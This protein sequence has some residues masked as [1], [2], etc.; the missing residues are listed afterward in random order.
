MDLIQAFP[1]LKLLPLM[2][3]ACV[4]LTHNTGLY[5]F[6]EAKRRPHSISTSAKGSQS[7]SKDSMNGERDSYVI[8]GPLT[9]ANTETV[10]CH[11]VTLEKT[12]AHTGT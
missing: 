1:Q 4:K 8:D 6:Q 7:M 5:S 9:P 12:K 3:L 11:S 10:A 2:T